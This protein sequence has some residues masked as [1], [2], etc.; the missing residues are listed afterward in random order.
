MDFKILG[1]NCGRD[2]MVQRNKIE[3]N[4]KKILTDKEK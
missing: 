3:K 4:I 2:F 1:T